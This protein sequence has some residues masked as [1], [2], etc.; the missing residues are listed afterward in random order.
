MKRCQ[1]CAKFMNG[2]RLCRTCRQELNVSPAAM[3][4]YW[5]LR[6]QFNHTFVIVGHHDLYD[7]LESAGL[8]ELGDQGIY[9]IVEFDHGI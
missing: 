9:Q 1:R 3:Q 6:H 8:I 4:L 5:R 2:G 7:E